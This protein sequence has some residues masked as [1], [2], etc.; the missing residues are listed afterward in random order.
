MGMEQAIR[1]KLMLGLHPERLDVVNESELHAG[2]RNSPGTGESHFR[3][4]VVSSAFDGL[5]RI[6]RHRAV[7]ALLAD[8]VG[9]RVHA[10]AL[11]ALTP[12]EYGQK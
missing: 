10:F 6:E 5:S 9:K 3:V 12:S 4:L 8:E 2:H 1:Q 11:T 7:N